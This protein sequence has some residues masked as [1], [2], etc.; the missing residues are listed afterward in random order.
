[1]EAISLNYV[2][3]T[4]DELPDDAKE[5]ALEKLCDS[6]VDYEWWEYTVDDAKEIGIKI[7]EFDIDHGTIKGEYY[8][9][10]VDVKKAIMKSH[11]KTCD[12]YQTVLE[13]DLRKNDVEDDLLYSLLQDYLSML[14][15]EYE[16]LTSEQAIIETIEANDYTFDINGNI[17]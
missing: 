2:V 5:S 13:Y 12:T 17:A 16:Y 4:F 14:R 10:A 9:D 8:D 3:Y 6:N 15:K 1:M 11:G 7:S